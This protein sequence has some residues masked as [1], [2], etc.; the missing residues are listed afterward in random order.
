MAIHQRPVPLD[1]HAP[2]G[3]AMTGDIFGPLISELFVE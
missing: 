3:L 2:P 1:G